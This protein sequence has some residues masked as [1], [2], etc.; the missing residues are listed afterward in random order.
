MSCF[1][2]HTVTKSMR[3][4]INQ[5]TTCWYALTVEIESEAEEA[6]QFGL[7]EADA[8]GT[9]VSQ[10][11]SLLHV[12]AYFPEVPDRER[13]REELRQ[14][15][16]IYSLPSSSVRAMEL[17]EVANEDWLAEWKKSWQPVEVGKRFIVGPPWSEIRNADNRLVIRI[18]P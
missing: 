16:R 18:E 17:R 12:T 6:V 9:E 14:A 2:I 11:H 1:L 4:A 7:M 3:P 5:P 13:V 10:D 8:M 15:L